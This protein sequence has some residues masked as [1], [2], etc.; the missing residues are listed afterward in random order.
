[1]KLTDLG[2]R[3]SQ[4]RARACAGDRI[5]RPAVLVASASGAT[6]AMTKYP[7]KDRYAKTGSSLRGQPLL[8][9][10]E[11]RLKQDT[12]RHG[13]LAKTYYG[14][15]RKLFS[16]ADLRRAAEIS[17]Q[18]NGEW[19]KASLEAGGDA[20]R[21][22]ALKLAAR[23]KLDRML[24]REFPR[25]R[26]WKAMQRTH[27]REQDKLAVLSLASGHAAGTSIDWG[28]LVTLEGAA[29]QFGAP[30]TTFDVQLIDWGDFVVSDESFA[31]PTIGHMVNNF[32]YDQNQSVSFGA[33]LLGILPIESAISMVSCGVAFTTPSAG[34]LR[35]SAALQ[36]IY[37]RVVVSVTDKFGFSS[38][39]VWIS[40]NLFVAVVRGTVVEHISQEL[41]GTHLTSDGGD[42]RRVLTDLDTTMPHGITVET[43]TRLGANESVLVLAGSEVVIGTVLDDMHC[44]MNAVLWWKL[45]S[46]AIDMAVDVIT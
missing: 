29:A 46:L 45:E 41:I 18:V 40:L 6:A 39:E 42:L 26:Q 30:F 37:N 4:E 22:D 21:V 19:R 3:H 13:R 36:N 25:Y 15:I 11:A 12:R 9:S 17:R 27:L 44:K 24:A 7:R 34:R 14:Q 28:N 38:A 20:D 8:A 43:S 23:R 33:G 16:K 35:I 10:R 2:N 5:T 1:M 32:A 31:R